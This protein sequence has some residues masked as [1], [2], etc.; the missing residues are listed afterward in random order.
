MLKMCPY[1][2][3]RA[4]GSL[5]LCAYRFVIYTYYTRMYTEKWKM[6]ELFPSTYV[7]SGKTVTKTHECIRATRENIVTSRGIKL[8]S[9]NVQLPKRTIVTFRFEKTIS[10]HIICKQRG[11]KLFF[12]Y[13]TQ[14]YNQ[15][16]GQ[17]NW[18][19]TVI[20][21]TNPFWGV[22][23][24]GFGPNSSVM[25]S[26]KVHGEFG[27]IFTWYS[28]RQT[29]NLGRHTP[30]HSAFDVNLPVQHLPISSLPASLSNDIKRNSNIPEQSA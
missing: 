18:N 24:S 20:E 1:L 22:S 12:K 23:V 10:N 14:I 30:S 13:V 11:T 9:L 29:R 28:F 26:P 8:V 3:A 5:D 27:S 19:G 7:L 25:K 2:S 15:L 17:L 21:C 6:Y 4:G 16:T